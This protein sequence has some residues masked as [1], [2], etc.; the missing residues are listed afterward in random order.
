MFRWRSHFTLVSEANLVAA[1]MCIEGLFPTRFVDA[2]NDL[3]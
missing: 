1:R 2:L 3:G